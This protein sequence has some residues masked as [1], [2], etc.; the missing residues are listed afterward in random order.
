MTELGVRLT[1]RP[2]GAPCTER[3]TGEAK[4]LIDVMLTWAWPVWPG[5][6]SRKPGEMV[7]R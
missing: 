3:L 7:M 4:L 5:G 1:V 6:M 2:G